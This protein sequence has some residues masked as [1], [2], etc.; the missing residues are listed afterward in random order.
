MDIVV[1]P[2]VIGR[3]SRVL[4]GENIH[5][6]VPIKQL[7]WSCCD[8]VNLDVLEF[9][10]ER[11]ES[12]VNVTGELIGFIEPDLEEEFV[13]CDLALVQVM[14]DKIVMIES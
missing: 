6:V 12:C 4:N 1:S 10:H 14:D 8:A 3:A 2:S 13:L 11:L 9:V 7:L 5:V